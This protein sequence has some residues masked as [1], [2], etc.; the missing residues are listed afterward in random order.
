MTIHMWTSKNTIK[1]S[2]ILWCSCALETFFVFVC[3]CARMTRA[4]RGIVEHNRDLA[5]CGGGGISQCSVHHAALFSCV[6]PAVGLMFGI[7][8]RAPSHPRPAESRKKYWPILKQR[9]VERSCWKL[10]SAVSL[11][12][13]RKGGST[14]LMVVEKGTKEVSVCFQ[15]LYECVAGP[16]SELELS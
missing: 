11:S 7:L 9:Q 3:I 10:K 15:C 16:N 13:W 8:V 12:G 4:H 14:T 1:T 6:H 2:L 5:G